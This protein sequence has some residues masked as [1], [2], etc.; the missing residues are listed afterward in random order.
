M[1][2]NPQ[3]KEKFESVCALDEIIPANVYEEDLQDVLD[4]LKSESRI[5]KEAYELAQKIL[6]LKVSDAKRGT[7]IDEENFSDDEILYLKENNWCESSNP[8]LKSYCLDV[9]SKNEKGKGRLELLEKASNAYLN[10]FRVNDYYA[11]LIRSFQ[12]R[13]ANCLYSQE[14]LNTVVELVKC[15]PNPAWIVQLCAEIAKKKNLFDFKGL[16]DWLHEMIT[17][18]HSDRMYDNATKYIKALRELKEITADNFHLMLALNYEMAGDYMS[19]KNTPTYYNW[20]THEYYVSAYKSI[21]HVQK[22]YIDIHNRIA[23]KVDNALRYLGEVLK[24]CPVSTLCLSEDFINS[25]NEYCSSVT[26]GSLK[27]VI[28]DCLYF[29]LDFSHNIDRYKDISRKAS[30]FTY[31]FPLIRLN[32]NGRVVG[33]ASNEDGIMIEARAYCRRR[34]SYYILKVLGNYLCQAKVTLDEI[35]SILDVNCPDYIE[36]DSLKLWA[37]GIYHVLNDDMITASHILMPQIERAL[38]NKASQ[39]NKGLT[40]FEKEEQKEANLTET[41]NELSNHMPKAI[42]EEFVHFLNKGADVN[43][44]NGLAHGLMS[45]E[46]LKCHSP[47]LFAIA[48]KVF[49]C[50]KELFEETQNRLQ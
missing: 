34:V 39:Y 19:S 40:H 6:K 18:S 26:Y 41:L 23:N 30:V 15:N 10:L 12:V 16:T 46:E 20:P 13:R 36:K 37:L 43:F 28:I 48:L 31:M 44:R 32:E 45:F 33:N 38:A 21:F 49:F 7:F 22:N 8:Q 11:Y 25:V 50:E 3:V 5:D 29:P 9:V 24:K 17:A 27:E 4:Q 2:N 1:E 47:Y 35:L 14:Y 42:H